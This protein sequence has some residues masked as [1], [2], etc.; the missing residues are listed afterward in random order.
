MLAKIEPPLSA[1]YQEMTK[2]PPGKAATDERESTPELA[3]VIAAPAN[4][5]GV[6]VDVGVGLDVGKGVGVGAG[7]GAGATGVESPL[8][9]QLASTNRHKG[10]MRRRI[11]QFPFPD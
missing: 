4:A 2:W 1:E 11:Q 8:P 5:T 3:T 10:A 9:P 7:A 6:G